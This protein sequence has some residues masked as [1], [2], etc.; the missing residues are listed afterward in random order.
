MN[1]LHLIRLPL[2]PHSRHRSHDSS[3]ASNGIGAGLVFWFFLLG[4]GANLVEVTFQDFGV[5][6]IFGRLRE[7]EED[8]ARANDYEAQ[9]DVHDLDSRAVETL[10][11]DRAGDDGGGGEVDVVGGGYQGGVED[12]ESFLQQ[13]LDIR[14]VCSIFLQYLRLRK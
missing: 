7:L 3:T 10:E 8:D 14:P 4:Y 11:E 9:N 12:V 2:R 13:M 1:P 6:Y 5:G